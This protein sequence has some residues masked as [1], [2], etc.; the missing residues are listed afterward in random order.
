MQ[1]GE[2]LA[3]SRRAARVWRRVTGEPEPA[4]TAPPERGDAVLLRFLEEEAADARFYA[5]MAAAAS[6][7]A[8]RTFSALASGSRARLRSLR[9]AYFLETG[10]TFAPSPACA[11]AREPRA[12]LRLRYA[13]E[14]SR[15]EAYRRAADSAGSRALAE[16]YRRYAEES[17]TRQAAILR[18]CEKLM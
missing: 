1:S 8:A 14:G 15:G 2:F 3:D 6:G 16:M 18:L 11:L 13:E 12:A 10:E 4:D 7:A 9:A 5:R 17:G